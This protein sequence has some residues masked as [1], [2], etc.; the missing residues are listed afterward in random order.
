[1]YVGQKEKKGQDQ[2]EKEKSKEEEIVD[3][4]LSLPH[5]LKRRPL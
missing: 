3:P 5:C 2:K 1:L 4:R